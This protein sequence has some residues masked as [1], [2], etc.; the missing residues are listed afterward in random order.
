LMFVFTCTSNIKPFWIFNNRH[1]FWAVGLSLALQLLIL[2]TP[3]GVVFGVVP[4]TKWYHWVTVILGGFS[5]SLVD[6]IRKW[7]LRRN[8]LKHGHVIT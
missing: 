5:V 3:M 1:L 6:E 8:R 4:L 2:Y 7:H